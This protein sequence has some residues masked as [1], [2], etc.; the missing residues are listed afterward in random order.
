MPGTILGPRDTMVEK[1][2]HSRE[3][4][5]YTNI[6]ILTLALGRRETDAVRTCIGRCNLV[7]EVKEGFLGKREGGG[8]LAAGVTYTICDFFSFSLEAGQVQLE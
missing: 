7:R 1:H 2:I 8:C 4:D 6:N 3:T 5:N